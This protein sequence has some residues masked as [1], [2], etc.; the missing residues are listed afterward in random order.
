MT[1]N[2]KREKKKLRDKRKKKENQCTKINLVNFKAYLK[3]VHYSIKVIDASGSKMTWM[4]NKLDYWLYD[5]RV[6]LL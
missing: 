4:P 1:K 5:S 6:L 3:H 2:R